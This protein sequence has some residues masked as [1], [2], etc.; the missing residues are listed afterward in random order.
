MDQKE[1]REFSFA[2]SQSRMRT[3]E[4]SVRTAYASFP[5]YRL[6]ILFTLM[7][8]FC[9]IVKVKLQGFAAGG[10]DLS[11]LS[12]DMNGFQVLCSFLELNR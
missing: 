8:F 10:K 3:L 4:S 1:T 9:W 11:Y 6:A 7:L 12:L 2:T 5:K